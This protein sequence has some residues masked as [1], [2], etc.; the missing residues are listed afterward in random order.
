[1]SPRQH[2][3]THRW[4]EGPGCS[5]GAAAAHWIYR[6]ALPLHCPP[7]QVHA[8]HY[9]ALGAAG[10]LLQHLGSVE[11]GGGVLTSG[12]VR[13]DLELCLAWDC[14][15]PTRGPLRL[16]V[17]YRGGYL[18]SLSYYVH[19]WAQ[20][21]V[22]IEGTTRHMRMD[23]GEGGVLRGWVDGGRDAGG[24]HAHGCR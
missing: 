8:S 6:S 1:M 4:E 16:E 9:L 15:E 14:W 22:L 23:A 5:R 12:T 24:A 19:V 21:R 17:N 11:A 3:A 7:N 10:A 20:V 2:S 18:P 13:V